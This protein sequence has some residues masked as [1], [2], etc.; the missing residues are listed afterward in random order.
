[1]EKVEQN[2][3]RTG[4]EM[5]FLHRIDFIP[6]K[7]TEPSTILRLLSFQNVE[8]L[9]RHRKLGVRVGSE[10]NT[11]LSIQEEAFSPVSTHRIKALL[12]SNV[13]MEKCCI[14]LPLGSVRV[15]DVDSTTDKI[16]T[17]KCIVDLVD[18]NNGMELNLIQNN[19]YSFAFDV[20]S[21]LESHNEIL[22]KAI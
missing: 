17:P 11:Y 10:E 22:W 4:G 16:R 3:G 14:I 9:V 18:R 21:S 12:S 5:N 2:P 7:P 20:L 15:K 13:S 1:M 19:C 6:L 8:G